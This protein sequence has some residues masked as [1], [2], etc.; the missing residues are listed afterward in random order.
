MFFLITKEFYC[1]LC[2]VAQ[3]PVIHVF[4]RQTFMYRNICQKALNITTAS[5]PDTP[6]YN[7][8]YFATKAQT[9]IFKFDD[10]EMTSRIN[11]PGHPI[12]YLYKDA[13]DS[14]LNKV[15]TNKKKYTFCF[16]AL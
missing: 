13:T 1:L 2:H 16:R 10:K 15:T 5:F 6:F 11:L 3:L 12:I 9:R 14:Y 8:A 7:V 4:F